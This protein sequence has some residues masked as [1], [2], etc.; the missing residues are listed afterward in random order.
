M[1]DFVRRFLIEDTQVRGEFARLDESWQAMTEGTDYPPGIRELLGQ[2][3]A[4]AVL[5]AATIKFDGRL[6]VQ[7]SSNGPLRLLLVQASSDGALRATARWD[8]A[9]PAGTDLVELCPDG[10]LMISVDTGKGQPYQGM[11]TLQGATL[12]AAFDEYFAVSDQLPTKFWLAAD[13]SRSAGL[14]LQKLPDDDGA[15]ADS[16]DWDRCHLRAATVTAGELLELTVETLVRRLFAGDDVRLYAAQAV[17]YRCDC[18]RERVGAMLRALA[19]AELEE[20][21][22]DALGGISVACEFCATAYLF[23]VLDLRQLEDADSVAA[24]SRTR[25]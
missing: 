3:C 6:T 11:V 7:V 8:D 19:N 25:H 5:L 17:F 22:D 12:A 16:D 10:Y 13:D 21:V 24:P 15:A 1:S 2:A 14:L 20:L 23:D 18:S 4:G 9:V